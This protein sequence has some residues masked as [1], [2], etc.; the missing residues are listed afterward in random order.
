M[1]L[2]PATKL[3]KRNTA[4]SKKIDDDVILA[5]CDDIIIFLIYGQFGVIRKP[6]SECKVCK[7]YIF[8]NR[9]L[10]SCKNRK[11]NWKIFNAALIPLL[12]VKVQFLTKND[13]FF[14]KNDDIS[15]IKEVLVLKGI[16]PKTKYVCL[17]TYQISRF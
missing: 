14:Q 2:A 7:T 15:T 4:L 17:L 9:N 8:I 3:D 13:T 10:L 6:D 12:W 16:F 11:Q 5:N 1:K